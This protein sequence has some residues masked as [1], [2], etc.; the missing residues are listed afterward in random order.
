MPI[1]VYFTTANALF[2]ANV[3]GSDYGDSAIRLG[4]NFQVADYF[5]PCNQQDL[6]SNDV[7]LGSGGVM[8]LPDQ[9]GSRPKLLTHAGKEGTI[10]LLDRTNMGRYLPTTVGSDQECTDNV[11]LKRWRVLG[12]APTNVNAN[13]N[14]YWG[15]PAYFSDSAGNRNIYYSGAYQPIMAFSLSNGLLASATLAGG[16]LDQ[17]PDIYPNGGTIPT[18]S[19]IGGLVGTA[20]LWAIKRA[21]SA[22]GYGPLALEAYDATDLTQR[23]VTD[24]PAGPWNH[25]DYAFLIPTVVNGKV[26]IASDGLLN[27]YGLAN[28]TPTPTMTPTATPTPIP[29]TYVRRGT[30]G[31]TLAAGATGFTCTLP[32]GTANG[33]LVFCAFNMGANSSTGTTTPP[34]GYTAVTGLPVI[35]AD[36]TTAFGVYYHLWQTGD[37]TTPAFTGPII[38]PAVPAHGNRLVT[39]VLAQHSMG[40]LRSVI[41][42]PARLCNAGRFRRFRPLSPRTI[43][44][45]SGRPTSPG[46][47]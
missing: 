44:S 1:P 2:D 20:V 29:L 17:T 18:V 27:V 10:Y 8:I 43:S 28:P 26:Y 3:G 9:I 25:H 11:V 45:C 34:S 40:R 31:G 24:L 23:L 33:D 15:A 7:D 13:R 42:R 12:D 16:A 14:A 35:T 36:E 5:T 4:L 46:P 19:S 41:R 22:D 47:P 21:N 37:T 39:K 38:Q 32:T 6:Y 30:K